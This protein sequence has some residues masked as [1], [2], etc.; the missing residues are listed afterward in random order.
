LS[1][2][3][4][5]MTKAEIGLILASARRRSGKTQSELAQA[6]GTTQPVIARAEGGYRMPTLGFID[7]WARATGAPISLRL[8]DAPREMQPAAVRRAMVQSV[9][10][11]GRFNPW[12]R[13]PS[14]VEAE[15][16]EQSGKSRKHFER[17]KRRHGQRR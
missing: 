10:G 12:D 11:P 8:G 13:N 7:R 3:N 9:L 5:P 16:L 1:G 14:P 4:S 15:L 6:M 2:Y 17:L